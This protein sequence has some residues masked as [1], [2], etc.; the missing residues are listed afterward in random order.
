MSRMNREL[1]ERVH[2]RFGGGGVNEHHRLAQLAMR[3]I[4]Q[5]VWAYTDLRQIQRGDRDHITAN[6]TLQINT[7]GTDPL[8]NTHGRLD[9]ILRDFQKDGEPLRPGLIHRPEGAQMSEW[10]H[11]PGLVEAYVASWFPLDGLIGIYPVNLVHGVP[12]YNNTEPIQ[13][14]PSR[15]EAIFGGGLAHLDSQQPR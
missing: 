15:A 11:D 6:A 7:H 12:R 14:D 10:L 5:E 13:T 3:R 1:M 8:G 9:F 2:Q 4:G